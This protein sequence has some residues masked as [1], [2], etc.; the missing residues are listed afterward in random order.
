MASDAACGAGSNDQ[1]WN[2]ASKRACPAS[3]SCPPWPWVPLQPDAA[4]V[5]DW[6]G[7]AALFRPVV[8]AAVL[9]ATGV[10]FVAAVSATASAA[11]PVTVGAAAVMVSAAPS[12][13]VQA[14]LVTTNEVAQLSRKPITWFM[15]PWW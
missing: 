6:I 2:C 15:P 1:L 13:G 3:S 10:I 8:V 11:V 12:S 7:A 4:C 9:A 14:A 5:P